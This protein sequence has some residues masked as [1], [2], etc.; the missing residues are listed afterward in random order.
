MFRKDF[1]KGKGLDFNDNVEIPSKVVTVRA[2][3][4]AYKEPSEQNRYPDYTASVSL[5]KCNNG[6]YYIRGDYD[7]TLHD[8]FKAG[9]DIIYGRFRKNVG[10]RDEYMLKQAL[11]DGKSV[12]QVIPEASGAGVR[13]WEQ[14]RNMFIEHKLLVKGA[15]TGNKKGGKGLRFAP[16]CSAAEQGAVYILTETFPNRATLNAFLSELEKFDPDKPST[17]TRKDDWVDSIADAFDALQGVKV[18]RPMAAGKASSS[19]LAGYRK[20]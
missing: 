18:R 20:S 2:W 8:D 17:G 3:D 6:N 12:T 19:S 1:L 9:Q 11:H 4:V 13:E 14:M 15:K 5:S 16:F 10:T 7:E